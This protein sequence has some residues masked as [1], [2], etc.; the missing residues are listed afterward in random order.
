MI[1]VTKKTRAHH[2]ARRTRI[3]RLAAFAAIKWLAK[4]SK[5]L[6]TPPQR[7]PTP[8]KAPIDKP[9]SA[10]QV[11]CPGHEDLSLDVQFL[12]ARLHDIEQNQSQFDD[13]ELKI[14]ELDNARWEG[15]EV[16]DKWVK[17]K[18][19]LAKDFRE[20]LARFLDCQDRGNK[21]FK[22]IWAMHR[23]I[24]SFT[25][26]IERSA[27]KG[28]QTIEEVERVAGEGKRIASRVREIA[29]QVNTMNEELLRVANKVQT[30]AGS[31]DELALAPYRGL[32]QGRSRTP[33]GRTA[34]QSQGSAKT[35][36]ETPQNQI[37]KLPEKRKR[38]E[39]D[40]NSEGI[41]SKRLRRAG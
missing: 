30:P 27:K 13:M 24:Q 12:T 1:K 37:A 25:Q 21:N 32:Q 40:D 6:G 18:K 9:G 29:E 2:A 3:R 31:G 5:T 11:N 26:K 14:R 38:N 28:D 20:V 19:K 22:L 41:W 15:I 35:R 10:N 8:E 4:I 34:P 7:E 16:L 17:E 23:H 39:P 33:Q 36:G